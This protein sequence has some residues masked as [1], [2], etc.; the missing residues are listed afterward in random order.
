MLEKFQ[1]WTS[2]SP[3]FDFSDLPIPFAAVATDLVT[4][5]AV[6][7][8]RGS[9]ASAMRASMAI[10]GLF[11]PWTIDGRLLVDGGLVSNSPVLIAKEIFGDIPIIVVDVTG[12]G[13]A[14]EDI[15]TVVDVVDQMI[16]IMTQ[17]NVMEELKYADLVITPGSGRSS[18]A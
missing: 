12:R 3:V 5:E 17:R 16:S 8:R 2:R 13:K 10:P 18:N 9:L 14:R 15:R 7:L 6:V 4:G 11:T 1:E